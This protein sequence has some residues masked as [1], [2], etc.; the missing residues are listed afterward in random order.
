[1]TKMISMNERGMMTLP[2]PMRQRFGYGETGGFFVAEERPE[3]ILLRPG[4]VV[5]L[6]N[7]TPGR[8]QE[9]EASDAELAPF[10]AGM[11]KAAKRSGR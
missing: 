8:I 11:R 3:G 4:Q 5:P 10:A 1:M 7:Y 2:K 9:F 6:E